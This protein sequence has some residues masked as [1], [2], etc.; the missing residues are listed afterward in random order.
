MEMYKSFLLSE[1]F[2]VMFSSIRIISCCL[3][4]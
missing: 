3:L 2:V 1:I 4:L